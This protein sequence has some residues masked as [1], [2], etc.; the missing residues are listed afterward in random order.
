MSPDPMT[1]EYPAC[2]RDP[3]EPFCAQDV[4]GWFGLS[5]SSYLVLSRT[6]MQEMSPEWQHAM[7]NLLERAHE[8]FPNSPG[9]YTVLLRDW[10]NRFVR[11][12][13]RDYRYPDDDAIDAA[14]ADREIPG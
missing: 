1:P 13:L 4:H 9:T 6:L 14:R 12:P 8:E 10:Q 7:V 3:V 11:D 5:Y 2:D